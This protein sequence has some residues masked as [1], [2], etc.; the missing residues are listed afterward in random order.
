MYVAASQS[1]YK[2]FLTGMRIKGRVGEVKTELESSSG[3]EEK[4]VVQ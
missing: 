4:N 3:N 1:V 2:R